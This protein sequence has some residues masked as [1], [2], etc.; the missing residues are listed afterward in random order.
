MNAVMSMKGDAGGNMRVD[1]AVANVLEKKSPP[2][3]VAAQ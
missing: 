3:A 2:A 1:D